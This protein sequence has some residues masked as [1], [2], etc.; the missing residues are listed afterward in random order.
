[1]TTS[2]PA[3]VL[4]GSR[5]VD[6]IG[7]RSTGRRERYLRI[8]VPFGMAIGLALGLVLVVPFRLAL[9]RAVELPL[10]VLLGARR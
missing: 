5:R 6:V 9:V 3:G 8:R 7:L 10:A 1:M 2:A 4:A